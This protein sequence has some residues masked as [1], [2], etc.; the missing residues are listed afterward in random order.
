MLLRQNSCESR[1]ILR[2]MNCARIEGSLTAE[3]KTISVL[4]GR[5]LLG[6][7]VKTAQPAH[8]FGPLATVGQQNWQIVWGLIA[9]V[10]PI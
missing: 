6:V 2:P 9:T 7:E 1:A 8:T 4:R 3:R 10:Y 5:R